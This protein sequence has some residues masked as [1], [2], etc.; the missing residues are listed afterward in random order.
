MKSVFDWLS[1]VYPF[2]LSSLVTFSPKITRINCQTRGGLNSL[3]W[4]FSGGMTEKSRG[5]ERTG[6]AEIW[7]S[8]VSAERRKL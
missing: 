3:N 8:G 2:C 7:R 6:R 5:N 1:L 4:N